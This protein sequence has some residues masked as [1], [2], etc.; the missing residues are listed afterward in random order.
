MNYNLEK[1]IEKII[2]SP[3]F[4]QLKRTV[5]NNPYHDHEDAF[6]HSIKI[7]DIAKQEIKGG[8]VTNPQAKELFVDFT[9]QTVG[10]INRGDIMVMTAL[11]HDIGKILYC[12]DNNEQ[13][14]I[15][16]TKSDGV[17][18]GPNHEYWGSTIIPVVLK[19]FALPTEV[20]TYI[21]NIV[22]LHDTF[23]QGY[24]DSKKGWALEMLIHDIKSRADGFYMEALFNIYCDNFTSTIFDYGKEMTI[25]VFNQPAL[26]SP[27][28]YIIRS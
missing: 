4:L 27:R 12:D 18:M 1:L 7:K 10:G 8:F 9:K 2:Q 13:K 5:E 28:K 24:F 25:E 20:V 17:T 15:L 6:S 26:Y 14:P 19:E 11:L 23:N 22:R 16:V 3:S 21:A